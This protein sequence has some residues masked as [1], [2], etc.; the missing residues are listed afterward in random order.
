MEVLTTKTE[1]N[2]VHIRTQ[3]LDDGKTP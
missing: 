2:L 1:N 3:P